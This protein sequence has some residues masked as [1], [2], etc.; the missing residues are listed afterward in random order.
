[1]G[2]IYQGIED[3]IGHTPL[4]RLTRLAAA[5]EAGAEILAK[6]ESFNPAGSAKDRVGL[7]MILDAE[8]AGL[9]KPGGIIIE[10]TSGNT[11]VG[12]AA[13]AA[14]RGYRTRIVMPDSMSEERRKLLKA[15]GAELILTDG[16]KGMAGAI[17]KAEE[18]HKETPGSWIA[19][20]FTNPSNPKAHYRT[21]GPE[22]WEDT[23]GKVDIFVASVGTGGTITGTAHYLWEKNP[24]VHV[25]AV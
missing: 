2:K 18:I 15:H 10:P 5:E 22:I 4:V 11:G 21:T 7:Q 17:E 8:E 9:L 24:S 13:A 19:G 6:M 14:A 3:L 16:A 25:A 23:D 1:M 12:L 20:Q